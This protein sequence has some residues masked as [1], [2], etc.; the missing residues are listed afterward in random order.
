MKDVTVFAAIRG[1][2]N[3]RTWIGDSRLLIAD[4]LG[5]F[6]IFNRKS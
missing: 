3:L 5:G 4:F 6:G 1:I 2:L